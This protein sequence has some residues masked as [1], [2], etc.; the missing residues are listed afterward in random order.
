MCTTTLQKSDH[1]TAVDGYEGNVKKKQIA[2]ADLDSTTLQRAT[3]LWQVYDKLFCANQ[4]KILLLTV[5][6]NGKCWKLKFES[7]HKWYTNHKPY[8]SVFQPQTA[9]LPFH[10]KFSGPCLLMFS[11]WPPRIMDCFWCFICFLLIDILDCPREAY[12]HILAKAT[13]ENSTWEQH[14]YS[15]FTSLGSSNQFDINVFEHVADCLFDIASIK[16]YEEGLKPT[17]YK[18]THYA[19]YHSLAGSCICVFIKHNV[20][21]PDFLGQAKY[22]K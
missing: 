17:S 20:S 7:N 11:R 13:W 22:A 12:L 6:Y 3:S 18:C 5:M 9:N 16:S 4:T 21:A 19:N 1:F 10:V 15:K 2:G 8:F 14:Y